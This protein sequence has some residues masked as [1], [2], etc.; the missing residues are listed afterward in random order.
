MFGYVFNKTEVR[1]SWWPHG[2]GCRTSLL[3]KKKKKGPKLLKELAPCIQ[4]EN[5]AFFIYK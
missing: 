5:V 4:P 2:L 3:L 1:A